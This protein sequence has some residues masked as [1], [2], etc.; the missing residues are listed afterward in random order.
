MTKLISII[1]PCRPNR[2]DLIT[3]ALQSLVDKTAQKERLE[4][5]VKVDIGDDKTLE[6][7]N[8]FQD[9]LSVKAILMDGSGGKANLAAY[10][11]ELAKQAT[12]VF[13][14]WWSD[15]VRILTDEWDLLIAVRECDADKIVALYFSIEKGNCGCY[16]MITK[17]WLNVTGRWSYHTP[18][19]WWVCMVAGRVP[20]IAKTV[21]ISEILIK[22][23]NESG[24]TTVEPGH[25]FPVPFAGDEIE[26][27][28]E[29][30]ANKI[31]E[32]YP[33]VE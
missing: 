10:T 26:A 30:D 28:L 8:S 25:A 21:L 22:D 12:G 6:A 23:T 15:E 32:A 1:I 17:K 3:G 33:D 9:K 2:P 14:W 24:E 19:D 4:V 7:V 16:P 11:N 18:I 29:K 5:L 20:N 31:K 13:V 27:E